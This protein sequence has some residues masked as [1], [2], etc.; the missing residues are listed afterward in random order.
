MDFIIYF[1]K[2]F[3][4]SIVMNFAIGLTI[5]I[6]ISLIQQ[7]YK[8]ILPN[9]IVGVVCMFVIG[10]FVMPYLHIDYMFGIV[11]ISQ[12]GVALISSIVVI[13]LLNLFIYE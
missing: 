1:L 2:F 5:G 8:N 12:I 11:N 10:Q 3:Q 7:D 4:N 6:L 9:I 13:A